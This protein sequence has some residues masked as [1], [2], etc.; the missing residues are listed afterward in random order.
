MTRMSDD[1]RPLRRRS[2][3]LAALALPLAGCSIRLERDAPK[4]PGIPTAA[5]PADAA[6]MPEAISRLYSLVASIEAAGPTTL[7]QTLTKWHTDQ[8]QE[9]TR[10]AAADGITVSTTPETTG[11]PATSPLPTTSPGDTSSPTSSAPVRATSTSMGT[12]AATSAPSASASNPAAVG[13]LEA[14]QL[15]QTWLAR[16]TPAS[17]RHRP[18]LLAVCAGHQAAAGMLAT[19][20]LPPRTGLPAAAAVAPLTAVRTATYAAEQLVAKTA[21]KNRGELSAL[22][23]VLYAERMR[24]GAEAAGMAPA[25]QLTFALPAGADDPAKARQT[26]GR[27]LDDCVLAVASQIDKVPTLL[28]ATRAVQLWGDLAAAAWRWGA[29]PQT[30]LGLTR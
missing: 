29:P 27:L 12:S 11:S 17:Q 21:L 6:L 5:P 22:L 8:A 1:T 2:V 19:T 3:V 18:A 13:K 9:L 24:L 23:T 30:F 25:E 4:I 26:M 10:L 15:S 7:S 20:A 28:A 16:V 14:A